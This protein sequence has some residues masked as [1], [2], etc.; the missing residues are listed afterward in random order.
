MALSKSQQWWGNLAYDTFLWIF[1]VIVELF[2]REVHPRSTWKVPKKGPVI[3]V[4]AP[5]ANQ[6]VDPLILMRILRMDAHRRVC[7]LIAEKSVKRA[8]I[9]WGSRMV[10]AVPVGRA[11]DMKKP[12]EGSVYLPKPE[13][14]PTLIRGNGTDFK[15]SQFEV[16]GLLVL[17]SV[18]NEAANAEIKEI[19]SANEMR[20]RKPFKGAVALRQLTGQQFQT[21][22]G[23][24][25]KDDAEPSLT[26]GFK[27]TKSVSYTHLTL[28]TKRIV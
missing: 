24:P 22:D 12:A 27:G 7:W 28:P 1:S 18:N 8:F 25:I 2:F 21:E 11:L 14:D 19:V 5:H 23:K 16:G 6:F 20:L 4:V 15:A 9:G 26:D 13:D 10:G 3:I 17:P